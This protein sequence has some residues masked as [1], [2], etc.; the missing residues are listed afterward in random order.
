MSEQPY[1]IQLE[2]DKCVKCGK[3]LSV[4]PSYIE[5]HDE[6]RVARG[7]IA[8]FDAVLAGQLPY[9]KNVTEATRSCLGC[10]RCASVCATGVEYDRVITELKRR[11]PRLKLVSK[12][13][14]LF[15]RIV[16]TRRWVMNALMRVAGLFQRLLPKAKDVPLT[17]HLPLLFKG[18]SRL[19]ELAKRTVLKQH[20]STPTPDAETKKT[21]Y[22][23]SGCLTNYAYPD[24][25]QSIINVLRH[26]GF[27]VIVP[28]GQVC[29]GTPVLALGFVEEVKTQAR[30]NMREM[31]GDA[32]ILTGCASCGETLKNI[33]PKLLGE[34]ARSLS[35][36]VYDFAEFLDKHVDFSAAGIR[37][38]VV[39]H[40]PCH[41]RYGQGIADAP[42]RLLKAAA[43]YQEVEG[44]DYCCGMAGLYSVHHHTLSRKIAK[45]KTDTLREVEA[46]LVATECP[47]CMMQLRDRLAAEGVPLRVR[48]VAQVLEEALGLDRAPNQ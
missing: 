34:E 15:F 4:C 12:W 13:E 29:C 11:I 1:S 21:V 44:A 33:Y 35:S 25:A 23:F 17:R 26:F 5:T 46:E 45:R 6:V 28:A 7:R 31:S 42:R 10:L 20:G 3:C 22:F 36:R 30:I 32:P 39:Y 41:L 8:L 16:L 47:A 2:L 24:V 48:H 9:S 40:D 38:R 43:R 27:D 19:P 14:R 18:G 37:T